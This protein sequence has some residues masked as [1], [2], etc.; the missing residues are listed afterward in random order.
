MYDIS[1]YTD[2]FH[3]GSIIDI[4][5]TGDHMVIL[6]ASAEIDEEDITDDIIL[7]KDDRTLHTNSRN[8]PISYNGTAL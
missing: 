6:M 2:F 4:H 1:K 5:H 8:F 7:S 3:D